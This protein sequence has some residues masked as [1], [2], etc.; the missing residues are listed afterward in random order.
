MNFI[1]LTNL[2]RIIHHAQRKLAIS[3]NNL[4][5]SSESFHTNETTAMAFLI[6]NT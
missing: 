1:G 4:F 2:T 3:L 5:N 6:R